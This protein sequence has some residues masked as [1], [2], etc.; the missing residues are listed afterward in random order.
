MA[1]RESIWRAADGTEHRSKQSA[2]VADAEH[3]LR[4]LVQ[5]HGRD[6]MTVDGTF[7]VTGDDILAFVGEFA[8]AIYDVIKTRAALA[9]HAAKGDQ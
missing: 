3:D 1:K 6:D 5:A 2:A 8:P 9:K 7:S 4:E